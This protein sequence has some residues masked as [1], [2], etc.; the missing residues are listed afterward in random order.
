MGELCYEML[1]VVLSLV[2]KA[3]KTMIKEKGVSE[4]PREFY[5]CVCTEKWFERNAK[6]KYV[7]VV[8]AGQ[9]L[10]VLAREIGVKD[11]NLLKKSEGAPGSYKWRSGKVGIE[12]IDF[13][14]RQGLGKACL[15]RIN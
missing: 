11:K 9:I 12:F 10:L 2:R 8:L 4:F 5:R 6:V 14:A 1:R 13:G 7:A 3:G 15:G